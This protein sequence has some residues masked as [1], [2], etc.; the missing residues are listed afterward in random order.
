LI[1]F[2]LAAVFATLT[3]LVGFYLGMRYMAKVARQ[4]PW[5]LY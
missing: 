4:K 5:K 3:F 2:I 1:A